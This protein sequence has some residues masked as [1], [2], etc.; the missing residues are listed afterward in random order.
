MPPLKFRTVGFPNTASSMDLNVTFTLVAQI[1]S[2]PDVLCSL[3]AYTH[4]QAIVR[5]SVLLVPFQAFTNW[6]YL[7]LQI[8]PTP[9][10]PLL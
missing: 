6:N 2:S 8:T 9:R 1:K 10:D 7:S 4:P 3:L 5:L